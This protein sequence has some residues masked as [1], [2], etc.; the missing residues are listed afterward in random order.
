[1]NGVTIVQTLVAAEQRQAALPAELAGSLVLSV[2]DAL[3]SLSIKVGPHELLLQEDGTIRVCGGTPSDET[4]SEKSLR[5]LLDQLLLC[6]S[7]VTPAL[8]RASRRASRGNIAELVRE[9]EVALIPTNRGASRRAL[10][11]LCREVGAALQQSPQLKQAAEDRVRSFEQVDA[12]QAQVPAL[13]PPVQ[14][15]VEIEV[16]LLDEL[17]IVELELSPSL[18]VAVVAPAAAAISAPQASEPRQP[19]LPVRFEIPD[20]EIPG[21]TKAELVHAVEWQPVEHTV[22]LELP[23]RPAISHSRMMP[24]SVGYSLIGSGQSAAL[25]IVELCDE[26]VQEATTELPLKQPLKRV[27]PPKPPVRRFTDALAHESPLLAIDAEFDAGHQTAEPF[28]LVVPTL[29]HASAPLE[30]ASF[31]DEVA[32]DRQAVLAESVPARQNQ[33]AFE[34][35]F[36]ALCVET[37]ENESSDLLESYPLA[38]QVVDTN[39]C[40]L[41]PTSF[42]PSTEDL[43]ASD[44]SELAPAESDSTVLDVATFVDGCDGA[45]FNEPPPIQWRPQAL[46]EE[47][48]SAN[49]ESMWPEIGSD[50]EH[51]D[52]CPI[53]AHDEPPELSELKPWEPHRYSAE[54]PKDASSH[55]LD[56]RIRAFAVRERDNAVELRRGLRS[57]AGLTEDGGELSV[58]PPPMTYAAEFVDQQSSES[59][60]PLVRTLI[61]LG[62][63]GALVLVAGS[64][65]GPSAR[66]AMAASNPLPHVESQSACVAAIDIADVPR[67]ASVRVTQAGRNPSREL[68]QVTEGPL[69]FDGLACGTPADLLVKMTDQGWYRVP[70]EPARL[71]P[72]ANP[73]P[74]HLATIGERSGGTRSHRHE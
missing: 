22:P 12:A 25:D 67:G 42:E 28:L 72:G 68:T 11:R 14:P 27:A 9:L 10:S 54:L 62:A 49:V 64:A 46:A 35:P 50:S 1:M 31:Y 56:A 69:R 16:E 71:S 23:A 6:S 7:S 73:E 63:V 13:P 21:G 53:E 2:A 30:R 29:E 52:S 37:F 48:P 20:L 17:D 4:S 18:P 34:S 70:I 19:E 26:D 8:L 36:G 47:V 45:I 65:V 74:I 39:G 55:D 32:S 58:T 38:L 66:T 24:A 40:E 61:G 44:C 59:N 33:D 15:E 57:L 41:A 43:V 5:E 3:V 60:G 51:F